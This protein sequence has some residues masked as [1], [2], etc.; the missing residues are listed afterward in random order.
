MPE[1]NPSEPRVPASESSSAPVQP[2][3]AAATNDNGIPAKKPY[4]KP[5]IA[6]HGNL[7]MMTQLE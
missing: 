1:P 5:T 7:R 4:A 6:R 3:A 2:P